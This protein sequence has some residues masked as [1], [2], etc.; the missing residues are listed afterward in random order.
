MCQLQTLASSREADIERAKL[1]A[2][3][4]EDDK[5]AISDPLFELA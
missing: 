5:A 2:I 3:Y 4:K 1:S